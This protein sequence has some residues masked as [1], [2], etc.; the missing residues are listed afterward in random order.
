MREPQTAENTYT[1]FKLRLSRNLPRRL[2][3]TTKHRVHEPS[4]LISVEAIYLMLMLN[5][6]GDNEMKFWR[7]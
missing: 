6:A 2:H 5:A 4:I 3:G 1:L 7:L